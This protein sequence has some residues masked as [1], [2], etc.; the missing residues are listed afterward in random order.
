MKLLVRKFLNPSS[1]PERPATS[2]DKCSGYC[3]LVGGEWRFSIFT[4]TAYRCRKC[5][6]LAYG[7]QNENR[8]WRALRKANKIRVRLGWSLGTAPPTRPKGMHM[9]TFLSLV[10]KHSEA[11]GVSLNSAYEKYRE[12]EKRPRKNTL[13][14]AEKGSGPKAVLVDRVAGDTLTKIVIF[15]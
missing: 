6:G 13:I 3:A 9:S 2:V 10:N 14:T 11:I 8:A 4:G 15:R 12:S 7:S 1:S 5:W